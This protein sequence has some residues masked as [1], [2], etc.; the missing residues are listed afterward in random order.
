MSLFNHDWECCKK[1]SYRCDDEWEYC[2]KKSKHKCD[3][4]WEYDK[5]SKHK[6]DDGWEKDKMSN[7]KCE[8]KG[9][10]HKCCDKKPENGAMSEQLKKLST[11][12]IIDLVMSGQDFTNLKYVAMDSNSSTATFLDGNFTFMADTKQIQA[13]R[14]VK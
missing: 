7:H 3:D 10:N 4:E 2:H 9:S 5:E 14:I 8:D 6:C 13:I 1:K 12:T 11:G